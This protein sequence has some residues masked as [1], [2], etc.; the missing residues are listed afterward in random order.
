[1]KKSLSEE[2]A[3]RKQAVFDS[4]SKRR[5]KFILKKGYDIWDPFQ[6][7]KDL[8]D[9]R[10]DETR[11]TIQMLVSDF[12]RSL[13]ESG[14]SSAYLGGLYEM[15]MGMVNRDDRYRAMYDFSCWYRNELARKN[16]ESV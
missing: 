12:L 3:R 16:H 9:I 13:P 14:Q 10:R 1:M 6:D 15:A 5:Q 4:M 7:P 8:I 11:R 2:M